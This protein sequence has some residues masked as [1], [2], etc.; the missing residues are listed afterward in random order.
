MKTLTSLWGLQ[1]LFLGLPALFILWAT[2]WVFGALDARS[3]P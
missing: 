2:A 3:R 1:L